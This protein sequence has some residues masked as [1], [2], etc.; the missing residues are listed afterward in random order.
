[1]KMFLPDLFAGC[2]GIISDKTE[3]FV[4]SVQF[5]SV[6]EFGVDGAETKSY[7]IAG[8]DFRSLFRRAWVRLPAGQLV[9][10]KSDVPEWPSLRF[11]SFFQIL[12]NP[13]EMARDFGRRK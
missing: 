9:P 12:T 7:R 5:E 6:S 11:R 4:G 8:T 13:D 10:A 2:S 1:M 3:C